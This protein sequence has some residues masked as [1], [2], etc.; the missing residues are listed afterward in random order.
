[1]REGAVRFATCSCYGHH[2]NSSHARRDYLGQVDYFAVYCP[3]T[4]GVYLVPIADLPVRTRA[5]LR[6]QPARNGQQNRI[7]QAAAYEIGKVS[8]CSRR[9]LRASSGAR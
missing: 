4:T 2:A 5:S 9:A 8:V 1:M 6:V 7:R 3:E